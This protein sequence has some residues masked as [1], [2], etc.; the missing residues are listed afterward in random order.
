MIEK[1]EAFKVGNQSFLTLEEA[2]RY[3]LQKMFQVDEKI[4]QWLV[5][6][7]EQIVSVLATTERSCDRGEDANIC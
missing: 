7:K 4:I 1:T 2:Q 3:E 5:A 6:N